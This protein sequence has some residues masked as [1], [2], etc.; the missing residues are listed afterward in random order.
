MRKGSEGPSSPCYLA[1]VVGTLSKRELC[2]DRTIWNSTQF[3]QE[4]FSVGVQVGEQRKNRANLKSQAAFS[5]PQ[6]PPSASC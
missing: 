6:T 2:G 1:E 5:P 4:Q 3:H